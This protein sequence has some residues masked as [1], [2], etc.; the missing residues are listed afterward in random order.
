MKSTKKQ[1]TTIKTQI[2]DVLEDFLSGKSENTL[3]AYS[4]DLET[5]RELMGVES[6]KTVVD[7]F[8]SDSPGEG[9]FTESEIQRLSD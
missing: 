9:K 8:L 5:F 4:R 3:R 2:P 7:I 6:R 1:P